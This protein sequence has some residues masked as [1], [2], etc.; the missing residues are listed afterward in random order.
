[1]GRPCPGGGTRLAQVLGQLRLLTDQVRKE[2][3]AIVVIESRITA[4]KRVRD[5][6]RFVVIQEPHRGIDMDKHLG[7]DRRLGEQHD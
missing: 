6:P 7:T 4:L 5:Q 2:T 1:M 3:I